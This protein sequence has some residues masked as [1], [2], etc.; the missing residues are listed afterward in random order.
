MTRME[1]TSAVELSFYYVR[2]AE[3]LHSRHSVAHAHTNAAKVQSGEA[4]PH[5]QHAKMRAEL[6]KFI[7]SDYT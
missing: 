4:Q 6:G 5:L 1:K 3:I 7:C 2:I